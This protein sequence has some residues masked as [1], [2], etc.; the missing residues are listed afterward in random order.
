MKRM[1]GPLGLIFGAVLLLYVL[2]SVFT[3]RELRTEVVINAPPSQVWTVLTDFPSHSDWNPFIRRISGELRRGAKL[4]VELGPPDGET[5]EFAPNLLAVRPDE[6]LRWLGRLIF[7]GVFDG[8]H[9]FELEPLDGGERTRLVH[10]ENLRGVLVPLMWN[11]LDTD[12]R[13]GFEA[14]NAALKAR[15][16]AGAGKPRQIIYM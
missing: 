12:T 4:S 7:P 9:I 10:R 6:E 2:W 8:E 1:L 13:R 15:V 16:E 3:T 14:M 11:M 5:M